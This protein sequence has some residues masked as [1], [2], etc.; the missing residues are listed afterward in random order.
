LRSSGTKPSH[1]V[2]ITTMGFTTL[3]RARTC[4]ATRITICDMI[5]CGLGGVCGGGDAGSRYNAVLVPQHSPIIDDFCYIRINYLPS[6]RSQKGQQSHSFYLSI[7]F[8]SN[9]SQVKMHFSFLAFAALA[10]VV[11]A[12][13]LLSALD[14]CTTYSSIAAG[15]VCYH[16]PSDCSSLLSHFPLYPNFHQAQQHTSSNP[17]T[18]VPLSQKAMAI[19]H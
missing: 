15:T 14:N 10:N 16:I 9:Y 6:L 7:S 1:R 12:T 13:P 4:C 3:Q 17:A 5:S 19:S 8:N 2:S 18:P 11:T